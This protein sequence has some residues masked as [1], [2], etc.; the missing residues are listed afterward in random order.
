M[1]QT[2]EN[3]RLEQELRVFAAYL[4]RVS[5]SLCK[6]GRPAVVLSVPLRSSQI[7][8]GV[9]AADLDSGSEVG[10]T[11][12]GFQTSVAR[13]P[14]AARAQADT[15]ATLTLDEQCEVAA[16]EAETAETALRQ[17]NAAAC[18]CCWLADTR[19]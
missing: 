5:G 19:R 8:Q 10:S 3:A 17:A 9:F 13:V 7:R 16:A 2:Q 11:A 6:P 14:T 18:T 1:L 4:A 15:P 12:P